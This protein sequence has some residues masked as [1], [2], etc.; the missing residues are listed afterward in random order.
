MDKN[1]NTEGEKSEQG[2]VVNKLVGNATK[3]RDFHIV[4][5]TDI[6]PKGNELM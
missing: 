3:T 1:L 6:D 5:K 4:G 2:I